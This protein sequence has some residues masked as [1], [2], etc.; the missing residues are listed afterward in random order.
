MTLLF[1]WCA[2]F[3][4]RILFLNHAIDKQDKMIQEVLRVAQKVNSQNDRLLGIVDSL[5]KDLK[6]A[7]VSA[8]SYQLQLTINEFAVKNIHHLVILKENIYKITLMTDE[9]GENS[10]TFDFEN[11]DSDKF[12]DFII[13]YINKHGEKI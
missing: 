8:L 9:E 6:I 11:G 3:F 4:I 5:T 2:Y 12:A 1:I 7:T 13:K 10:E